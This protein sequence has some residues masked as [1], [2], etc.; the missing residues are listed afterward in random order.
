MLG[1]R[2]GRQLRE[3]KGDASAGCYRGRARGALADPRCQW[4]GADESA[5]FGVGCRAADRDSA[6]STGKTNAERARRK[7]SRAVAGRML[8]CE[9][10]S[11]LVRCAAQDRGVE[12][13]IQRRTPAQ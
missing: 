12:N 5:F 10:V 8:E 4:S 1:L 7:L 2:I 3:P 11:K 6:H 13:R 9:L